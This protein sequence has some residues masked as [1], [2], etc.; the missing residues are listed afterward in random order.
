[1]NL[2]LH[3][4]IAAPIPAC[5]LKARAVVFLLALVLA[6]TGCGS[7]NTRTSGDDWLCSKRYV[8]PGLEAD[9]KMMVAPWSEETKD[10]STHAASYVYIP[11]GLFDAPF[12]MAVDTVILPY[13][14]WMV[15][16]GGKSRSW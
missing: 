15:T 13:D 3:E 8:Y 1:M 2:K 10:S 12:S 7:I 6:G 14:V 16:A 9:A 5:H 11:V 4:R